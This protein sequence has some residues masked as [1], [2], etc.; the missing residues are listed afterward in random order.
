MLEMCAETHVH[1]HVMSLIL[2][3]I[4]MC[5]QIL[6]QFPN[7]KFHENLFSNVHV[8]TDGQTEIL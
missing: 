2:S 7:V 4:R 5:Q 1:I 6:I 8:I 3:K